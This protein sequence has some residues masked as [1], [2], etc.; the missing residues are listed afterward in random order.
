MA[1]MLE[2]ELKM[3]VASARCCLGNHSATVLIAAG[4]FPDSPRPSQNRE[5]QKPITPKAGR[6]AAMDMP[7]TL[8][9]AIARV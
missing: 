9:I 3:P 1:P 4:K 2:P 6:I 8:Q 7:A 5:R